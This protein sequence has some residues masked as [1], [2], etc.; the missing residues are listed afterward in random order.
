M[1][2]DFQPKA[3]N[4]VKK[5]IHSFEITKLTQNSLEK[6]DTKKLGYIFQLYEHILKQYI[7]LEWKGLW[8]YLIKSK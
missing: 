7:F 6:L 1:Y 5:L 2:A 3:S 8:Q 4:F